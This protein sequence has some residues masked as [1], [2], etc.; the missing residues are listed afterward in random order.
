QG[1]YAVCVCAA[2]EAGGAGG[3]LSEWEHYGFLYGVDGGRRS[4]G[5]GGGCGAVAAGWACGVVAVDG[6]G[7]L[8]SAGERAGFFEWFDAWGDH[9]GA[10]STGRDG[11][12]AV[13]G[14]C[15]V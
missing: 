1:I 9:A 2:G 6:G 14:A 11:A 5:S 13:G 10:Q 3:E 7:R 15:A 4:A 8:V 12:E